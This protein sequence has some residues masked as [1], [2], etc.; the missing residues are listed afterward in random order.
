MINVLNK[1]VT[2]GF[3]Q[4][5]TYLNKLSKDYTFYAWILLAALGI[6]PAFLV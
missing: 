5:L 1:L 3:V 4:V 2:F 6:I